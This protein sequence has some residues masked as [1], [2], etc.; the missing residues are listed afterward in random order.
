M[1][2]G[3]FSVTVM[4][5]AKE[6]SME[7]IEEKRTIKHEPTITTPMWKVAAI[8]AQDNKIATLKISDDDSRMVFY[9]PSTKWLESGKPFD[10]PSVEKL[11]QI[12][13]KTLDQYKEYG[14]CMFYEVNVAKSKEE[15]H[16]VSQCEC[17]DFFKKSI[18]KHIIG[19]ALRRKIAILP[20]TA[21]PTALSQ[22]KPSGRPAKSK[23]ALLVQ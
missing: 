3:Q 17:P 19:I 4:K 6:L 5:M 20:K 21:I 18:C 16:L 13:W 22:K 10:L 11:Q 15:W 2:F 14:H 8:W 7:Y 23:K 1:P 9:A 12:E